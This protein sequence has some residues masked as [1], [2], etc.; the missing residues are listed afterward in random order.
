MVLLPER[1]SGPGERKASPLRSTLGVSPLPSS[2][3]PSCSL[4]IWCPASLFPL[5][6]FALHPFS[7]SLL[8]TGTTT[9]ADFSLRV[10]SYRTASPFQMQSEISPGKNIDSPRTSAGYTQ[11]HF[12]HNGFAVPGPLALLRHASDPV[13]VRPASLDPRFFQPVPR[14]TPAPCASLGSLW[15]V[16]H[17]TSTYHLMFM[18]GTPGFPLSRE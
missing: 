12:G 10:A 13:S 9:S 15:P 14:G 1:S 7:P 11:L 4:S 18:L 17:R 2:G 3:S 6:R 16:H 8:Q 5:S